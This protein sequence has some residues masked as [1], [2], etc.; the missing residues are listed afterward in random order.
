MHAFNQCVL[1]RIE[2]LKR[3]YFVNQKQRNFR[4]QLF[5]IAHLRIFCNQ[6]NGLRQA[7][8]HQRAHGRRDESLER[9]IVAQYR[10]GGGFCLECPALHYMFIRTCEHHFKVFSLNQNGT[11]E[12]AR[13]SWS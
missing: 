9:R 12:L 7:A 4:V 13:A 6:R 10:A 3:I 5:L 8:A 11:R 2:F 1:C